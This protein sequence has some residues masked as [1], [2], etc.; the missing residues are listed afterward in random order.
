[1]LNKLKRIFKKEEEVKP[2]P[3]NEQY[4]QWLT[5]KDAGITQVQLL[6]S[7]DKQVCSACLDEDGKIYPVTESFSDM[8]LP[9]KDCKNEVCRCCYFAMIL[10]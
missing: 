7:R 9:H 1:M 5:F 6:S 3:N 10:D 2:P 8:P 4:Q